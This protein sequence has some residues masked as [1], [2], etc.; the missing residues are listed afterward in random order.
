MSRPPLP[1]FEPRSFLPSTYVRRRHRVSTTACSG[2]DD[3]DSSCAP[4]MS[5]DAV[6]PLPY[7]RVRVHYSPSD[8]DPWPIP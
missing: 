3:G 4:R 2:S 6:A 5:I 8:A 1:P 7:V